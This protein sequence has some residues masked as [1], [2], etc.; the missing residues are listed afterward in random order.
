MVLNLDRKQM[1]IN[2]Q[3]QR[4]YFPYWCGNDA[5]VWQELRDNG[6]TGLLKPSSDHQ[7]FPNVGIFNLVWVMQGEVLDNKICNYKDAKNHAIFKLQNMK[8]LRNKRPEPL[9]SL[10]ALNTLR[11][12]SRLLLDTEE[13]MDLLGACL[14]K[15]QKR[16][17]HESR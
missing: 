15:L 10:A 14:S 6:L 16:E 2:A 8:L 17:A 11:G 1:H 13:H 9:E 12:F 5:A 3:L 7:M 4:I